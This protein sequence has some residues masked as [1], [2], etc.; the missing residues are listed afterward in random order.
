M[1]FK[2]IL[3]RTP[4]LVENIQLSLRQGADFSVL[5]RENSACPSANNGGDVGNI[6][7]A[8]LPE[9]IKQA[10]QDAPIGEV[11]GPVESRHGHHLIKLESL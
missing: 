2:H 8:D 5:A 9:S 6:D 10:L 1:R 3:L 7:P 4:L 11:I